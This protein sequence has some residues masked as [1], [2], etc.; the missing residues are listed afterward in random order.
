MFAR[1]VFGCCS[2]PP[3]ASG[4]LPALQAGAAFTVLR[5]TSHFSGNG[6]VLHRSPAS[7]SAPANA[8]ASIE[9]VK[10]QENTE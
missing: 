8:R 2:G 6:R 5:Q 3:Q 4:A 1:R 9:Q 10:K 7:S